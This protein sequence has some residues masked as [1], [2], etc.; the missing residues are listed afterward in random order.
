M[1]SRSPGVNDNLDTSPCTVLAPTSAQPNLLEKDHTFL[2]PTAEIDDNAGLDVSS[3]YKPTPESESTDLSLSSKELGS[4]T[5]IL[6]IGE[7][8][9]K[10]KSPANFNTTMQSLTS[11]QKYELITKHKVP[12]KSYVFPTQYLGGC[13]CIAYALTGFQST[14]GWCTVR[15]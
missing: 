9:S 8:Y 15:E 6:D 7:I 5:F 1:S 3:E 13:N 12:H 10:V 2:T 4:D 11:T 14:H